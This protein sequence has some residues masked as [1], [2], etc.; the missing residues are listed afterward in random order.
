M[1]LVVTS[2]AAYVAGFP[3]SMPTRLKGVRLVWA[4]VAPLDVAELA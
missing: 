4:H 2:A 3:R 1:D